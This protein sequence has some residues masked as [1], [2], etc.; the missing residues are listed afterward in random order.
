MGSSG[1]LAAKSEAEVQTHQIEMER[2]EWPALW[3]DADTTRREIERN[4]A[5]EEPRLH[6]LL[7]PE[8]GGGEID[9]FLADA[10]G[11][12][13]RIALELALPSLIVLPIDYSIDVAIS[14]ELGTETVAT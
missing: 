3:A 7:G 9:Q 2:Q 4:D 6:P 1:Y 12:R 5:V 13:L 11:E 8:L 10:L 14:E